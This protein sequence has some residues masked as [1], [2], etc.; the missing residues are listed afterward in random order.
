MVSL[1]VA[2]TGMPHCYSWVYWLCMSCVVR[3]YVFSYTNL[4][5]LFSPT[6]VSSWNCYCEASRVHCP[7]R[8]LL[9]HCS[10]WAVSSSKSLPHWQKR[11]TCTQ[12]A[13]VWWDVANSRCQWMLL[14]CKLQCVCA[15]EWRSTY[16]CVWCH[17]V[18]SFHYLCVDHRHDDP[19]S[20]LDNLHAT[21]CHLL[22]SSL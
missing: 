11:S 20:L 19:F 3:M 16:H 15:G 6:S 2:T 4:G 1:W 9:T 21:V 5:S 22:L 18:M 8:H 17:A 13:L 10:P 14:N 7:C 12:E